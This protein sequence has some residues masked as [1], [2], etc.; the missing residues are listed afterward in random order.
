M[1]CQKNLF[2]TLVHCRRAIYRAWAIIYI[3]SCQLKYS[4]GENI[5]KGHALLPSLYIHHYNKATESGGCRLRY[6]Y[7]IIR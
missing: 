5:F 3:F 7:S 2:Y 4:F 1:G 6:Q